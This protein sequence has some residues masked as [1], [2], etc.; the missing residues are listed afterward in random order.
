M[1][2]SFGISPATFWAMTP[3]QLKLCSEGH[4]AKISAK[5]NDLITGFWLN[6]NFVRAQKMPPLENYKITSEKL[7]ARENK[8]QVS[9]IDQSAIMNRFK[10]YIKLATKND[11]TSS[12]P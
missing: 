1:A 4:R 6:A 8:E 12:K 2:F 10:N 5:W 7:E 11:N 3:W 9:K